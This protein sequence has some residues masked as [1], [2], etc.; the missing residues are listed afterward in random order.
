MTQKLQQALSFP[1][2]EIPAAEVTFRDNRGMKRL[3]SIETVKTLQL[4]P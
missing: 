3:V 2:P 1:S 4:L